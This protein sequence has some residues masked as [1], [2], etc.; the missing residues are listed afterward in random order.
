MGKTPRITVLMAIYNCATTLPEALDSMMNQ[1]YQE[2]KVVLCDDAS[3][4]NTF[5]VAT[6]YIS[7]YPNKFILI[8]NEQNSRLP[9]SLNRCLEYADTEYVARMDGDDISRQDRFQKEIE[10]LDSH[11]EYAIVS[12]W[13][14]HFDETGVFRISKRPEKPHNKKNFI[15]TSPHAHAPV[16]IKTEALKKVG[17][18]T[19]KRWTRRGQDAHLWAKLYSNGFKGY[20]LQES[21]YSMRDD[22]KAFKRRSLKE[23]FCNF[24]RDY[25]IFKMMKIPK[26]Y[27]LLDIKGLI[28]GMSPKWFYD[29]FHKRNI[30]K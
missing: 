18:Y 1:T 17:G 26:Y 27:L 22:A 15:Q 20:N 14:E 28:V 11:P 8:R 21:L 6:Q 12:T 5:D 24:R 23:G 19:V 13:M 4:D 16:M 30:K 7:K 3:T 29:I 9:Y 10:F 2:F 25:D